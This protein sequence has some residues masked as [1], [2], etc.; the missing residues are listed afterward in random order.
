MLHHA[1]SFRAEPKKVRNKIVEYKL[2]LLAHKGSGFD[3]CVVINNLPQWRSVVSLI[4]NRAGVV[5]L[6]LFRICRPT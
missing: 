5:F 3:S 1:L 2:Y 6:N 4:R